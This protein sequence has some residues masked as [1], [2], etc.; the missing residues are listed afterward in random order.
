MKS[1]NYQNIRSLADSFNLFTRFGDEFMDENPLVGEPGSFIMSRVS[2][3]ADRATAKTA[4][5]VGPG[6][7]ATGTPLV[8]PG[9]V[10][11]P[12]MRVDTPGKTSDKSSSPPSSGGNKGK[13]RRSRA[14]S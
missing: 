9:R 5:K 11:T 12:Q 2:G 7:T 8:P 3:D 6:A 10:S 14:A 4:A 13:R 1:S